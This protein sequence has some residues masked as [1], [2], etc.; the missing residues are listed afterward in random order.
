VDCIV[1]KCNHFLLAFWQW[2]IYIT[3]AWDYVLQV[4]KWMP[5]LCTFD[6]FHRYLAF[7]RWVTETH[8][9][10]NISVLLCI[11]PQWDSRTNNST[12]AQRQAQGSDVHRSITSCSYVKSY[13]PLHCVTFNRCCKIKPLSK[14]KDAKISTTVSVHDGRVKYFI[15]KQ[16]N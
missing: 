11:T 9:K 2:V 16:I 1:L 15:L 13:A 10:Q 8:H 3:Y 5:D 12:G 4:V 6:L 7:C 14:F